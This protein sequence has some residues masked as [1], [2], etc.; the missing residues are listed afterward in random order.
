MVP[1]ECMWLQTAAN[2]RAW[3]WVPLQ[4]PWHT[5][6]AG[7]PCKHP[8]QVPA[9]ACRC[10]QHGPW[11]R[12]AHAGAAARARAPGVCS[13]SAWLEGHCAAMCVPA[14]EHAQRHDGAMGGHAHEHAHA[15]AKSEP[16]VAMCTCWRSMQAW[17]E[18]RG[19]PSR[20][21][22]ARTSVP[23]C[24]GPP[25]T[26]RRARTS[27]SASGKAARRIMPAHIFSP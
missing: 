25:V 8:S 18:V 13:R 10:W 7:G 14:H 26:A 5:A 2:A 15:D 11:W 6:P 17:P 19:R 22:C 21:S 27:P 12:A 1:P 9:C 20:S 23:L 3:V 24:A 16:S 4:A